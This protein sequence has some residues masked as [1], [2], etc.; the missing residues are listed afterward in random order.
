[1]KDFFLDFFKELNSSANKHTI[2]L[3]IILGLLSGFLPTFTFFNYVIWFFVLIFRIP[4]GL[5][6]ASFSFFGGIAYFLD[7]L[8]NKVGYFLL[9][10]EYLKPFWT[11]LYNTPFLRWSGFNNTLVM[12][13]L[14]IGILVSIILYPIL[15]KSVEIYREVVFS[16]L[17]K[18]K[19]LSWLVPKEKK[20]IF[21]ISGFIAIGIVGGVFVL[22]FTI[23]TPLIGKILSFVLSKSLHQRV[24]VR[25]LKIKPF[26]V[27][28][29]V[30]G[31]NFDAK[32]VR[33]DFDGYYLMWRKFKVN[34]DLE[35]FTNEDLTKKLV[36]L[37]SLAN[38]S[39]KSLKINLKLDY[40]K[41]F[42]GYEFKSLKALEKLKKD[43][44]KVQSDIKNLKLPDIKVIEEEVK[45]IDK[46]NPIK[47]AKQIEKIKSQ[48]DKLLSELREDEKIL[49][50]DKKLLEEDLKELKVAMREDYEFIDREV[51]YLKNGNLVEFS[52]AFLAPKIAYYVDL[53]NNLYKKIKPY[54]Q[55]QKTSE[56]V[57]IPRSGIYIKFEDKIKYPD[58]VLVRGEVNVKNSLGVYKLKLIN[59]SNNQILLN[60][61]GEVFLDAHTNFY[62]VN[63]KVSYLRSVLFNVKAKDV[64][65]K[66]IDFKKIVFID[67]RVDFNVSGEYKKGVSGFVKGAIYPSKVKSDLE[68][69][70]GIDFVVFEA[71]VKDNKIQKISSNLDEILRKNLEKL[72]Q[73]EAQKLKKELALKVNKELSELNLVGVDSNLSE[74][75]SLEDLL[76]NLKK[77]AA[78]KLKGKLKE[79]EEKIKNKLREKLKNIL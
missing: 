46:N 79:K 25:D 77:E 49:K 52:K 48:I 20:S 31:E 42:K 18:I 61:R 28:M 7:P 76:K 34:G 15:L 41:I 59:I 56:V 13:S 26:E 69:L 65:I 44:K 35:L 30:V 24:E 21:R 32:R 73:K 70:K 19:Y 2:V 11:L 66:E 72:Y 51:E 50:E 6:M 33:V 37:V 43:Y 64:K 10:N 45:A 63:S 78:K 53:V 54:L 8:F 22:L 55:T 1:M 68:I 60:K 17:S 16:K 57:E 9:T 71:Y 40:S 27:R 58:F 67:N 14:A 38:S 23:L 62:K 29:K 5:Y 74:I 3:A 12:G 47:A 75:K 36:S 39:K 4:L